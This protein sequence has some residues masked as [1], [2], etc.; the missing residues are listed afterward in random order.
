MKKI[1]ES[2]KVQAYP[3]ECGEAYHYAVSSGGAFDEFPLVCAAIV[4]V[5]PRMRRG[6]EGEGTGRAV[7]GK[8]EGKG[9]P[10]QPTGFTG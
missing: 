4:S 9:E 1:Q 10:E 5:V 6:A 3:K 8:R 2:I 7:R